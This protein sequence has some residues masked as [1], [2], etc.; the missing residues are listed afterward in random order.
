MPETE[1]QEQEFHT[2]ETLEYEFPKS[3]RITINKSDLQIQLERFK[4]RIYSSFS[5]YDLLAIVSLWSPVL[6]SEFK[7]ILGLSS[8]EL[9]VGYFVFASLITIF[10]LW[11]R[12]VFRFLN[13]F[14]K[15]SVSVHPEKM[16][17]KILE[18]CNQR[19]K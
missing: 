11:S 6:G 2:D 18:Q 7:P 4:E 14:K 12:A 8:N 3:E 9:Q 19:N 15:D 17:N 5:V 13:Y 1:T 10:V 16:V